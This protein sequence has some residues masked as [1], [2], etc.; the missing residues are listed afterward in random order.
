MEILL[1]IDVLC[2]APTYLNHFT[3]NNEKPHVF[4]CLITGNI[5]LLYEVH[6]PR[7][8]LS[9]SSTNYTVEK[10]V[11]NYS[12]LEM[13][14]MILLHVDMIMIIMTLLNYIA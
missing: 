12:I 9:V 14:E 13:L 5:F 1:F 7:S 10:V 6:F 8:L 4:I 2:S 3:V 11:I